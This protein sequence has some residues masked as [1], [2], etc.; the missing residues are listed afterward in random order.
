MTTKTELSTYHHKRL[1]RLL[2][3]IEQCMAEV[4]LMAEINDGEAELLNAIESVE[5]IPNIE[6]DFRTDLKN[7]VTDYL[8]AKL[9]D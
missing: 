1:G 5:R 4:D 9:D 2:Y 3:T 8:G 7:L 6:N